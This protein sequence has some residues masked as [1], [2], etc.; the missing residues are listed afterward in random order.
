M[1][2]TQRRLAANEALVANIVD[3]LGRGELTNVTL[4]DH[5]ITTGFE[6]LD[7]ELEGGFRPGQLVVLGGPPGVGK[8]VLAL[9][10]ARSA[11]AAGS[12]AVFACYE[13]DTHQLFGRLL[14]G[15]IGSLGEVLDIDERV[16]LRSVIRD[17]MSGAWAT[18][19]A[20]TR[21]PRV[22]AALSR[23]ETYANR[24]LLVS[25]NRHTDL[26]EL[27]RLAGEVSGSG[28]VLVVD[29]LQKVPAANVAFRDRVPVV[30]EE[31]KDLALRHGITVIALSSAGSKSLE[32][33]RIGLPSLTGA[34]AIAYEADLAL[35]MNEK[36]S[37]V[38]RVHVNSDPLRLKSFHEW[39]V[40][41]IEKNRRGPAPIDLEFRKELQF[42]R[43]DSAGRYV[44][45]KLID[46]VLYAE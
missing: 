32:E 24:L 35:I 14:A 36:S 45:E 26:V 44:S 46:D 33:R 34:S 5:P 1:T 43:F 17:A 42:F 19:P 31:L 41:T 18:D 7:H 39:I 38:S 13:H 6:P 28:G 2:D 27:D 22:R 11:A 23:V 10:F 9:Q 29:Y 21:L 4:G 8:T 16:G 12:D 25:A 20:S 40:L 15:E 30:T 37:I 3:H